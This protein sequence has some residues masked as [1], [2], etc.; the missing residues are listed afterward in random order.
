MMVLEDPYV[1]PQ[2]SE[3]TLM[4]QVLVRPANY[5]L[6]DNARELFDECK[7]FGIRPMCCPCLVISNLLTC[8]HGINY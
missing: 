7:K 8:T 3:V 4:L 2:Q 5:F 1:S 6:R